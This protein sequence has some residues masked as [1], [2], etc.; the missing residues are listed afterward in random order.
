VKGKGVIAKEV[1]V[2][3]STDSARLRHTKSGGVI[4]SEAEGSS[5]GT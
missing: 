2:R 4:V 5:K 1:M 3:G